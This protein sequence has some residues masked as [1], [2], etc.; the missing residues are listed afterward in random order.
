MDRVPLF[1]EQLLATK[2]F[3]PSSS[4]VLIPRP[5]LIRLLNMSLEYPL[6]LVQVR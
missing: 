2:F 5:R 1:H 4:H 6:T 3:I